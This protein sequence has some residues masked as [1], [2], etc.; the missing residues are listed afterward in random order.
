MATQATKMIVRGNMHMD[1]REINAVVCGL[2]ESQKDFELIHS[3][4]NI[5]NYYSLKFMEWQLTVQ[6]T[7]AG[8]GDK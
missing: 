4:L 3:N 8:N 7:I 5:W 2:K 1:T 6:W